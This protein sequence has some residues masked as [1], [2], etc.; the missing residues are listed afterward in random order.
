MKPFLLSHFTVTSCLGR[1][2]DQTLNALHQE[3]GGLKPCA[4][5]TV[6]LTTYVGEVDGVDEVRLP[7][8]LAEFDCRNNRLAFLGLQQDGYSE[9]V[10]AA[11]SKYGAHRIGVF[12]GTSTSGIL[13]T[14]RAYRRR[15]PATGALPADF[16]YRTTHNAF[17][18]AYFTQRC[19]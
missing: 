12:I 4:F 11:S 10:R 8:H 17:S 7:A 18:A 1:G 2:L 9:A 19:G 6:D 13:Q 14:E 5:D 15:D 16:N 3:R